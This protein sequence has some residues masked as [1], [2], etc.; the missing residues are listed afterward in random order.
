RRSWSGGARSGRATTVAGNPT[1]P[2]RL[3]RSSTATSSRS[4]TSGTSTI[5]ACTAAILGPAC[6]LVPLVGPA[7]ERAFVGAGGLREALTA[8]L[9]DAATLGRPFGRRWRLSRG[10]GAAEREH[11]QQHSSEP[12]RVLRSW[13]AH[14]L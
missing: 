13:K 7:P 9:E 12:H 11:P 2:G 3:T 14:T 6:S 10:C 1:S 5:A 8:V 4:T